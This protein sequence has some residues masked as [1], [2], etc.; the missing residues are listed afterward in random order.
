MHLE[1]L[2]HIIWAGILCI[3]L[4]FCYWPPDY[5]VKF[6]QKGAVKNEFDKIKT[7]VSNLADDGGFVLTSYESRKVF[8][9]YVNENMDEIAQ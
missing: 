3:P 4:Y 7:K 9:D 8:E 2:S 1:F 5:F 6:S